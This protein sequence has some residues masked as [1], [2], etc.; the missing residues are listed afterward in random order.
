[1]GENETFAKSSTAPANLGF[2][3]LPETEVR[4]GATAEEKDRK[5]N[6]AVSSCCSFKWVPP[7]NSAGVIIQLL[8]CTQAKPVRL[9][10]LHKPST[11][12]TAHATTHTAWTQYTQ[13]QPL[14]HI[15]GMYTHPHKTRRA[16]GFN[17]EALQS[18]SAV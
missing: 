10:H 15:L 12:T 9:K 1:M 16:D 5:D 8:G 18:P 11:K 3:H 17:G 7:A 4:D 6:T 14:Q 13:T 2:C